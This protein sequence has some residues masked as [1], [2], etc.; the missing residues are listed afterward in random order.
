MK[1]MTSQKIIRCKSYWTMK[2]VIMCLF[3]LLCAHFLPICTSIAT[4]IIQIIIKR[5]LSHITVYTPYIHTLFCRFGSAFASS[6]ISITSSCPKFAAAQRAVPSH[7]VCAKVFGWEGSCKGL[8]L[9][10]SQAWVEMNHCTSVYCH[11]SLDFN[12][13]WG[14]ILTF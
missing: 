1:R 11:T 9:K 4:I 6:S 7:Y 10:T 12:A 5:E 14:S 2:I 13:F 8:N 3:M